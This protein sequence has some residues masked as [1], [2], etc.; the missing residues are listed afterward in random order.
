MQDDPGFEIFLGLNKVGISIEFK[1][2]MLDS[3]FFLKICSEIRACRI[4]IKWVID[5]EHVERTRCPK[6]I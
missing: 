1:T 3:L 2:I 4:N 5:T 6:L